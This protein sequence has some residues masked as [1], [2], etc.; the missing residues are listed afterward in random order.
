MRE[1]AYDITLSKVNDSKI[2]KEACRQFE[3]RYPSWKK[4][5]LL[6]DVDGSTIQVYQNKD[7]EVVIYD[8]YDVGAVFARSDIDLQ[9]IAEAVSEGMLSLV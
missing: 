5:K 8:D 2:F 1:Y 9:L 4:Q 6:I 7:Q 3:D